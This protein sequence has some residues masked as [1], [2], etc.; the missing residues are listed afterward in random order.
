MKFYIL[1]PGD[2]EEDTVNDSN[3][4]GEISFKKFTKNDGFDVLLNLTSKRPDLLETLRIYDSLGK[5][6]T[7]EQFLHILETLR[8]VNK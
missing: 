7:V 3:I 2:T 4:L 6:Y 5:Q 1:L 8:K